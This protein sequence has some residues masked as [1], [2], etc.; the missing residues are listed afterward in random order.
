MKF[1]SHKHHRR[2]IRLKGFDYSQPGVYFI[3]NCIQNREC[4][5]GEIVDNQMVLNEFGKIVDNNWQMIPKHFSQVEL[6]E[7]IIMP[8]H[9][10]GV[11][12]IREIEIPDVGAKHFHNENNVNENRSIG[13]TD[14][15]NGNSPKENASP[16]REG[17]QERIHGTNPG[18]LSAIMQ[19]YSS[20]TTRI[21]N[22]IGKTP[23]A[24]FWQRNFFERIVRDEKELNRIRKYIIENPL[25]WSDDEYNPKNI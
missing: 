15:D 1:D 7:Y 24:K 20:V 25:K 9:M 2:S 5:L 6:D 4:L 11:I 14:L 10:H 19:N 23:G 3:T 13:T 18:S 12:I 16:L 8:N 21:I 22:R 17:E